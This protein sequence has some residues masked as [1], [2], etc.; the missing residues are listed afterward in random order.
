[1]FILSKRRLFVA[2][3]VPATLLAFAFATSHLSAQEQRFQRGDADVDGRLQAA[4]ATRVLEYLF[5]GKSLSCEQAAD[6]DDD[7]AIRTQDAVSLLKFLFS[8]GES[9]PG[10]EACGLDTTQDS[11]TCQSYSPCTQAPEGTTLAEGYV[12]VEGDILLGRLEDIERAGSGAGFMGNVRLWPGGVVPFTID[13][14]VPNQ[15]RIQNAFTNIQNRTSIQFVRRTTQENFIQI[16]RTT[17]SSVCGRSFLGMQDKPQALLLNDRCGTGTVIH[18]LGHALGLQHEH[19]RC[20]RDDF[21]TVD[22][23]AGVRRSQLLPQTGKMMGPYDFGSIMH[24][25]P[26]AITSKIPGKVFGQRVALSDLDAATIDYF[27]SPC[28]QTDTG[29]S[30]GDFNGDGFEDI[31]RQVNQWGGAEVFLSASNDRFIPVGRWTGAGNRG[32]GWTVGDFNGDGRDDIFRQADKWGG[33]EVL[34]ST[35]SG[36]SYVGRWTGAGH[37]GFGWTVGDF[38]GDGRDDISR[39]VNKWGGSEMFLSTGSSFSY[40]GRWTGAGHRGH[41]W[42]VGDFNA[43]GRD[44]IFRQSGK[45]GGAEMFLS[46]GRG[47]SYS[48]RWTGGG[49]RNM[50]WTVGDFNGDGQDD[51]FRQVNKWGGA[52]VFLSN[53]RGF[54]YTGRWTG[55]GHRGAGFHT[56]D[57]DGD[58]QTDI[59]RFATAGGGAEVLTSRGSSFEPTAQFAWTFANACTNRPLPTCN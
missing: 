45:W 46:T 4:D 24:Y 25:G 39:Q 16:Q 47:F 10:P 27:Y 55:A 43:D 40:A 29:W 20:D 35:G 2:S 57:F 26:R 49:H 31:F 42:K 5:R 38:N 11:L 14:N 56:G 41:G 59:F 21:I 15:N 44:D 22:L 52:E 6:V 17:D 54:T 8:R 23:D 32:Y 3:L 30:V 53:G 58:G 18:E 51:I 50:G 7:G 37:R 34:L 13:A 36:F 33:A 28:N 12:V 9:L 48:G 1:M 19:T